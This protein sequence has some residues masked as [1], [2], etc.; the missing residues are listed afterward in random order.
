MAKRVGNEQAMQIGSHDL[1]VGGNGPFGLP[2][3]PGEGHRA[4]GA[5]GLAQM[6][7]VAGQG[8]AMAAVN[9]LFGP[10]LLA[11][12]QAGFHLQQAQ[13]FNALRLCFDTIRVTD[14]LAQH[15][16]PATDSQHMP[17][18]AHMIIQVQIPPLLPE[19]LQIGAGGLG[20]GQN[21]QIGRGQGLTSPD[22]ADPDTGMG[23]QGVQ[24]IEIGHAGQARHHHMHLGVRHVR[25]AAGQPQ[26]VLGGQKMGRVKMGHRTKAGATGQFLDLFQPLGKQVRIALKAVDQ[27]AHAQAG[28]GRRNHL[29]GARQRGNDPAPGNVA[30]HDH[31]N[32]F[33]CRKTEICNV[34]GAQVDFRGASRALHQYQICLRA[35]FVKGGKNRGQVTLA[36]SKIG[37]GGKG[38]DPGTAQDDLRSALMFRLEQNRVHGRD[39]RPSGRA[40]LKGLGTADF[41]PVG[42]D[43]G[44]VGHVLGLEGRNANATAGPGT[45]QAGHDQ[46]LSD[47]GAGSHEHEGAGAHGFAPLAGPLSGRAATC[48][49]L[50]GSMTWA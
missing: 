35:Q 16:E 1:P 33:C 7:V 13:P 9:G 17:S 20:A 45:A 48:E 14:P 43:G 18:P 3:H 29:K 4:I 23:A 24:I 49:G 5:P 37:A 26:N 38:G 25:C 15:L 31:R 19:K 30:D 32:V 41:P 39:R 36:G 50:A 10:Q 47:I 28:I 27:G 11:G 2:V 21:D 6:H 42:S 8:L 12:R 22:N 44:I 46:R 34:I 40:G